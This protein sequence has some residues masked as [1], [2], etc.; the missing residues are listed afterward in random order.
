MIECINCVAFRCVFDASLDQSAPMPALVGG[1]FESLVHKDL[2]M[3]VYR[4]GK[5]GS[6]RHLPLYRGTAG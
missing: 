4:G 1:A 5:W 6:Y 3:N 2:V